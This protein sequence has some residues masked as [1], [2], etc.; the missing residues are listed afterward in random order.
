MVETNASRIMRDS[1]QTKFYV[2]FTDVIFEFVSNHPNLN[3]LEKLIWLNLARKSNL[4]PNYSCSLTQQQIASMVN[5]SYDSAYRAV[6]SLKKEGFLIVRFDDVQRI[7]VYTPIL[8][9]EGLMAI[10]NAPNRVGKGEGMKRNSCGNVDELHKTI[11]SAPCRSADPLPVKLQG[12]PCKIAGTPPAKMQPLLI[13]NNINNKHNNHNQPEEKVSPMTP[14]DV[15]NAEAL[16]CD[17]ENLQEQYQH[18]RPTERMRQ[19]NSQFTQEE[20]KIISSAIIEKQKARELQEH[21]EKL[22]SVEFHNKLQEA[23]HIPKERVPHVQ[24]KL[25]EFE[26]EEEFFLIEEDV[27]NQILHHIPVLYRQRKIRGMA[28]TKPLKTL[29]KEIFYYVTK[30]GSLIFTPV[31]QLKRFYI[32]RKICLKG[33]WERPRGMALS[34]AATKEKLWHSTKLY[35]IKNANFLFNSIGAS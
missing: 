6:R 5:V 12:S 35:E 28:G 7:N 24:T 2:I 4:D 33:D 11:E 21:Q 26:F 19:V 3:S 8:P 23:K 30:A 29:L 32:A 25:V 13:N 18:L 27:K 1:T 22:G 14:Q 10:E 34:E 20:M 17:F 15:K 9:I 16:V 31:I